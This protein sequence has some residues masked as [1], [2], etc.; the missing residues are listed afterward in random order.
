MPNVYDKGREILGDK[1]LDW[2]T[3]AGGDGIYVVLLRSD[4]AVP[5]FVTTHADM[6]AVLLHANN[7]E[8]SVGSYSRE[9]AAGKSNAINGSN[10]EYICAVVTWA[11]LESGQEVGAAVVVKYVDGV[12]GDLPISFHNTNDLTLNGSAVNFNPASGVVWTVNP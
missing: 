3:G 9:A 1:T 7:D 11:V 6:T 12:G 4:L 10:Y 5:A 8:C 2:G